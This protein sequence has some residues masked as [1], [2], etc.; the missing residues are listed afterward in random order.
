MA[1]KLY[2]ESLSTFNQEINNPAVLTSISGLKTFLGKRKLNILSWSENIIAIPLPIEIELPPLGN[3][4]DIDIRR[5]EPVLLV[6]DISNYP[7]IAPRVYPDRL[8]F[9]KD[10]LAHL[11][12]AQKGK[13]PAFCLVRENVS[14]WYSNKQLKDFV[15]R[16]ANWFRD[17]A[18]GELTEDGNQFDPLRLEGYIGTIIYDYDLLASLVN[19]KKS[20]SPD[21]N[22]GI[23][24]FERIDSGKGISFKLVKVITAET[25]SSVYDDFKKENEKDKASPSR[26]NYHFGYIVWSTETRTFNDYCVDLPDDWNGFKDYCKKYDIDL[27]SLEKQIAENDLNVFIAIPVITAIKRPK[28]LIGFSGNIEFIN[29]LL[30]VDSADVAEGKIANNISVNFQSH[31]QPL[32]RKKAK[33]IS[34]FNADLGKYALIAGCGALGSKIVMH[35]ARSGTTNYLLADPDEISPHNLVRHALYSGSEG[36]NKATGLQKEIKAMYPSEELSLLIAGKLSGE[37]WL[38]PELIK[39]YSWIFDF[40]ASN[41]FFQ[42]LIQVSTESH[43]KVCRAFISDGGN[44]GILFLEGTETRGLMIYRCCYMLSTQKSRRYLNG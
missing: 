10:K 11:Y 18:T 28:H 16:V 2:S 41:A 34:G 33:E 19:E 29:F 44:L 9:P 42:K 32:S 22:F 43:T 31:N 35:L 23:G 7:L 24:L 21:Q 36:M 6:L 17:A 25:I 30:K 15:I 1:Q 37:G 13:P 12:V 8:D 26:R 14:E 5:I 38:T 20:F 39:L 40:T 4:Q 27:S 3:F